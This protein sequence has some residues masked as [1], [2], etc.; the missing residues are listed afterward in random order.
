VFQRYLSWYDGNPANLWKLPPVDS[1]RR[2]VELAGGADNLLAAARSA[3]DQGEYRW[4]AEL[5]NHLVF[6]DPSNQDGRELQ[7]DMLEQLGYQSESA[8][9]RNAF[10]T[11]AQE[12]RN[13]T[14]APRPATKSSYL[15][16][17]TIDQIFD[18]LAVKLKS[19]EVGGL[20]ASVNFTLTDLDERWVLRLSN[21]TLH[22]VPGR[23]DPDATVTF[24]LARPVLLQVVEGAISFADAIA[25]GVA[26]ADGDVDAAAAI[27]GHLDV[28]MTNFALVEP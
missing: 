20:S 25:A 4:G 28:F 23:H 26:E 15:E 18:S 2:Y 12:L 19:E 10:L 16:A 24:R 8:T 1:G 27:F 13:G 11:G 14:M 21:R 5:L 17:M 22:A 6:A 3:F 7:A 9:F